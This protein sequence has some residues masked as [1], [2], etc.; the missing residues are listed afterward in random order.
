MTFGLTLTLQLFFLAFI[1]KSF[2]FYLKKKTLHAILLPPLVI[3][4]DVIINTIMHSNV[5]NGS[6]CTEG[7]RSAVLPPD[8]EPFSAVCQLSSCFWAYWF[9]KQIPE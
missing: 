7:Q 5:L 6:N 3:I 4:V 1:S 2:L 9:P 8:F